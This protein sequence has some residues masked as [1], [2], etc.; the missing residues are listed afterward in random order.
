LVGAREGDG[1]LYELEG[2]P[3]LFPRVWDAVCSRFERLWIN[4]VPDSASFA[5]FKGLSNIGWNAHRHTM[6]LANSD[7]LHSSDFDSWCVAYYDRI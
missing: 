7:Q 1:Y 4:E 6:W 3:Y 5:W 2:D